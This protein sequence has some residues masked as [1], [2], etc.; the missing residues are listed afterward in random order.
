MVEEHATVIDCEGDYVWVQTHRQSSCGHCSVK[1]GCGTQILSKVLGNK[2]NPVRCLNSL[3][4]R[5]GDRVVIGME[6][7]ALL[8][9][10]LL[11]YF[12]PLV[13]MIVLAAV[14]IFASKIG[15]SEGG[16]LT[17]IIASGLGLYLGMI[18]A[19]HLTRTVAQKSRYEPVVLKKLDANDYDVR[20]ILR[21]K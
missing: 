1:N 12:L 7:S 21:E 20:P 3:A 8:T 19:N 18:I 9:G 6:E 14:S 17:V 2:T 4:I 13:S 15:W 16:D 11:V 5:T 10:S